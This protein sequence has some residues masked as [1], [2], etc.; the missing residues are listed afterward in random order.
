MGYPRQGKQRHDPMCLNARGACQCRNTPLKRQG[1]ERHSGRT[2]KCSDIFKGSE[3]NE[4]SGVFMLITPS[5]HDT[6]DSEAG[7]LSGVQLSKPA[8]IHAKQ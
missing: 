2:A 6:P 4:K 7:T 3:N 8:K 5:K 1:Q